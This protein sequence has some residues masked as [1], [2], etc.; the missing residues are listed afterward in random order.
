[1]AILC[2]GAIEKRPVVVADAAGRD[3]I[4]IRHMAYFA[5]TYDHRLIDGADA[6]LFMR[7]VKTTL[8][9]ASWSELAPAGARPAA[10]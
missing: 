10:D 3:A 7:D 4:A 6:E 8:E 2:V 5:L 1:V 9:T